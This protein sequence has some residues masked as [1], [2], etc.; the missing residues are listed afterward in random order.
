MAMESSSSNAGTSAYQLLRFNKLIEIDERI[1]K[2]ENVTKDSIERV[3]IKLLKSKP[4]VASIGPIKNLEVLE[5]IQ[6]R[7]S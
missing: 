3:I 4:T 6:S 7:F 2:I 1:K 5:K